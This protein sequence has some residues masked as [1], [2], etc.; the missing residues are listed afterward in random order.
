MKVREGT[1]GAGGDAEVGA[2]GNKSHRGKG[3]YNDGSGGGGG[4][5]ESATEGTKMK[6]PGTENRKQLHVENLTN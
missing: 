1:G 4:W 5:Q 3:S 2:G 6:S